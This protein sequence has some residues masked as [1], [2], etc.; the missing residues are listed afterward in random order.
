MTEELFRTVAVRFLRAFLS[1]AVASMVVLSPMTANS[2]K[3][4]GTWIAA[5]SMAGLVG[6]ITGVIMG[7]DKYLRSEQ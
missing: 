6:G 7:A 5:L 1:G 4:V 3:D 2:W